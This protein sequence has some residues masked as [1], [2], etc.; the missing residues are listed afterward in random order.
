M[1]T[2][3]VMTEARGAVLRISMN[4]PE[5]KNALTL[6]M[7]DGLTAALARAE[8]DDALRVAVLIGAPGI[9]TA[10]NDLG[11]FMKSPPTGTD[12]PVLRFLHKLATFKKPLIAAVDGPAVGIGTTLLFHCDMVVATDRARFHM[13]FTKLGLVPEGASSLLVPALV[14]R[15]RATSWLMLGKP[16]DAKEAHQAGLVYE[17]VAPD[18]LDASAM[19]LA[20]QIC[21]LPREAVLLTKGLLRDAG[22]KLV[23]ET[24]ATE[25]KMFIERLQSAETLAAMMAFMTKR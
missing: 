15:Q 25:G 18:V 14:G 21:E 7:Y 20:N 3:R 16:F 5:K 10:G 24:I 13:P 19:A 9:F 8:S 1:Q 6:E 23:L 12:S 22:E 4:R 11:D 17:V 2:D